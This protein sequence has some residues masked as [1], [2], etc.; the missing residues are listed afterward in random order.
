MMSVFRDNAGAEIISVHSWLSL[1]DWSL[2]RERA[3][4]R[5]VPP[6]AYA[7]NLIRAHFRSAGIGTLREFACYS[8]RR[9][10]MLRPA[11]I[12]PRGRILGHFRFLEKQGFRLFLA[13]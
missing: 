11:P 7:S 4:A 13:S 10:S 8:A 5:C 9:S 3:A 6:A 2:L 1:G 12:C